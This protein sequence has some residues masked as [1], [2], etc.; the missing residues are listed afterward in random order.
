[1]AQPGITIGTAN[2]GSLTFD[3]TDNN[4][5]GCASCGFFVPNVSIIVSNQND[6]G[7]S[8]ASV[9]EG[10]IQRNHIDQSDTGGG[11][12]SDAIRVFGDANEQ[13]DPATSP[14]RTVV[15]VEDNVVLDGDEGMEVS[16]R[17][18][19]AAASANEELHL[20]VRGNTFGTVANPIT[21][22]GIQGTEIFN[23]GPSAFILIE[24]NDFHTV[25]EALDIRSR[26]TA[27]V[28]LTIVANRDDDGDASD[29][30]IT[31][32]T[33]D[34][35]EFDTADSASGCL[36]IRNNTL[37]GGAGSL[38]L[39]EDAGTTFVVVQDA[40]DAAVDPNDIDDANGIPAGNVVVV[41]GVGFNAG[42]S[43]TIPTL[44]AN[45]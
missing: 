14:L 43:C 13:P 31:S 38:E 19:N 29:T 16:F 23:G 1:M 22:I 2:G 35:L 33:D 42:G 40:P 4:P 7:Q 25:D 9:M 11:V 8:Q 10:R 30:G 12:F 45:S 39:D 15:L 21:D 3:I 41:G 6:D 28:H 36:D 37:Q 20:T 5:A 17:Q 27:S 34:E 44:P 18:V 24:N 32:T 26:D